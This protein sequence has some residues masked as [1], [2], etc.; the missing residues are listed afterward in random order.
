MHEPFDEMDQWN[1]LWLFNRFHVL[2]VCWFPNWIWELLGLAISSF[3][4]SLKFERW[5]IWFH[6]VV[7]HFNMVPQIS[8][9]L[10]SILKQNIAFHS[11]L[12]FFFP[13]YI[14]HVWWDAWMIPFHLC[15]KLYHFFSLYVEAWTLA[16]HLDICDWF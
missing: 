2:L 1:S 14:S 12:N 8:I 6:P 4:I 10:F 16:Y 13:G 5:S 3:L 11:H 15:L 9:V 7:N